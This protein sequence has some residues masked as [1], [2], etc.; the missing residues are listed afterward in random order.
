V[1]LETAARHPGTP[2]RIL[3]TRLRYLGDVILTTPAIS[4]LARRYPRAEIHYL[5]E[6]PY[7]AVLK[8]NPALTGI[9]ELERGRRGMLR[10]VM[11]LRRLRFAAAVDFFY[12][13]RSSL[14]LFLSG[15]P[16]RI[17]GSRRIRRRLYTHVAEPPR[18]ARSAAAHHLAFLAPLDAEAEETLPRVYLSDDEIEAGRAAVASFAGSHRRPVIAIHPGGTWPA[19]RWSVDRFASLAVAMRAELGADVLAVT[20]P[21]EEPI[22][23]SVADAAERSVRPLPVMPVRRVAGVL[24]ACDAIVANDGGV[25]HLAVALGRPTVAVFGPTDPEIWF[26][27]EGKG[28]YAIVTHASPCAPCHKHI[29]NDEQCLKS[30]RPAEV[31]TRLREVLAWKR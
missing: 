20:G 3:A 8:G 5:A 11:A 23:R 2:L 12:N 13:P 18:R 15:I 17:G 25:M 19:K 14:L 21:G 29:C 4:A 7:A 31:L 6:A 30:I 1:D 9:I 26:P 28:P 22:V 24:A 16:V 10:A 27:Y